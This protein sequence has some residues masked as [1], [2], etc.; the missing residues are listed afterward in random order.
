[1]PT[2][3]YRFAWS[4]FILL[5]VTALGG[6]E[7][8][9][10]DKSIKTITLGE[11]QPMIQRAKTEP[12]ALLLVDPRPQVQFQAGHLPGATRKDLPPLEKKDLGLDPS[13]KGFG[14]IVVYGDD[15]GSPLAPAMAKRLL[16]LG[17]ENVRHYA[18]GIKEWTS[19]GL[20]LEK[21]PPPAGS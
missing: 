17:Y 14:T 13:M 6:C 4:G 20:P 18:G 11:L 8:H 16:L 3:L 12:R 21:D 2:T 19:R 15:P 9:I 7:S 1:M 10:S 5:A